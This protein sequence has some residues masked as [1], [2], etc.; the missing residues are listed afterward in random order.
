MTTEK[1]YPSGGAD[2]FIVRFPENMRDVIKEKAALNRRSMN[3]EIVRRLENSLAKENALEGEISK[4][5]VVN[6]HTK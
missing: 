2:Q 5:S 6:P 4:A 3:N 1:K